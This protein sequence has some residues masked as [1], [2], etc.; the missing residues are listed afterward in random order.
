LAMGAVGLAMGVV[1][2]AMGVVGL[3]VGAAIAPPAMIVARQRMRSR[4]FK[5]LSCIPG[6]GARG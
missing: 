1:G 3:G 2:L 4:D 5:E 6:W